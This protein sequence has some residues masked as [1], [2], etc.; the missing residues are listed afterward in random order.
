MIGLGALVVGIG[1]GIGIGWAIRGDSSDA[2][3]EEITLEFDPFDFIDE[4]TDNKTIQGSRAGTAKSHSESRESLKNSDCDNEIRC[5]SSEFILV[6]QKSVQN[7]L[8]GFV[9]T[10]IK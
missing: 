7:I 9:S 8:Q 2:A 1:S 4:N 5:C 6:R 10:S 3:Q